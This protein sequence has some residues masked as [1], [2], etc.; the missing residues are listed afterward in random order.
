MTMP[1]HVQLGAGLAG[2]TVLALGLLAGA[3]DVKVALRSTPVDSRVDVGFFKDANS[4]R[5]LR[6]GGSDYVSIRVVA[7]RFCQGEQLRLE[8]GQ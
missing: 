1:P 7:D 8:A 6:V 2:V 5:C 3:C 4:G